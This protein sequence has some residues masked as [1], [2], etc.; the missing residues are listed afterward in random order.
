[1]GEVTRVLLVEDDRNIVDLIR[2]NLSVRGYDVVVSTDGSKVLWQLE[3]WNA[4]LSAVR[5]NRITWD[6]ASENKRLLD[7]VPVA[8]HFSLRQPFSC[9]H[10]KAKRPPRARFG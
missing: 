7:E 2:S 9:P 6:E 5:S 3:V 8:C 1:M 4:L 10:R